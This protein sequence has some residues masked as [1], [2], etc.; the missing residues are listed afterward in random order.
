M[1]GIYRSLKKV[2]LSWDSTR[3]LA[4]TR[5]CCGFGMNTRALPAHSLLERG[6]SR[7]PLIGSHV[8]EMAHD[9]VGHFGNDFGACFFLSGQASLSNRFQSIS[10]RKRLQERVLIGHWMPLLIRVACSG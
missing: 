10:E 7:I 8:F 1:S 6:N 3:L 9:D 2:W 4:S 5:N